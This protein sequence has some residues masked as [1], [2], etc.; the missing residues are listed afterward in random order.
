MQ[1]FTFLQADEFA[2][3]GASKESKT[4]VNWQNRSEAKDG[5]IKVREMDGHM[6]DVSRCKCSL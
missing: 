6:V 5:A 1:Y 4:R 3:S 2:R